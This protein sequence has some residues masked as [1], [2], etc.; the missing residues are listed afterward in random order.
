M[1]TG[2][3]AAGAAH[4]A[5][6]MSIAEAAAA[7]AAAA[8]AEGMDLHTLLG[9]GPSAS[10]ASGSV[11]S[12]M[13]QVP[14]DLRLP[15]DLRMHSGMSEMRAFSDLRGFSDLRLPSDLRMNSDLRMP[16]DLMG[17]AGL[18]AGSKRGSA[19]MGPPAAVPA[20]LKRLRSGGSGSAQAGGSAQ[21]QPGAPANPFA[22]VEKMGNISLAE[23]QRLLMQSG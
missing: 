14:H 4:G 17:P 1:Q 3:L 11:G 6:N 7:A 23:M 8:A 12:G 2:G 5:G 10:H 13:M 19:L 20:H 16:S 22:A 18:R 9:S 15:S 21:P